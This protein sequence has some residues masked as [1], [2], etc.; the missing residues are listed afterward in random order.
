MNENGKIKKTN[1][2]LSTGITICKKTM[3]QVMWMWRPGE[4]G[5]LQS[6]VK[7]RGACIKKIITFLAKDIIR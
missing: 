3:E 6:T 5:S 7:C 2:N 4:G 1:K